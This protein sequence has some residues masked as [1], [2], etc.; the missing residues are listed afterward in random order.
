[1]NRIKW[2]VVIGIASGIALVFVF[3]PPERPRAI[4]KIA[5]RVV[6]RSSIHLPQRRQERLVL[7]SV[8]DSAMATDNDVL[9]AADNYLASQNTRRITEE[10]RAVG[11]VTRSPLGSVVRYDIYQGLLPVVGMRI[12]VHVDHAL[13]VTK[14]DWNYRPIAAVELEEGGPALYDHVKSRLPNGYELRK[15]R[16][17]Y[18]EIIYELFQQGRGEHAVV[19]PVVNEHKIPMSLILRASDGA[20]L[21]AEMP[22]YEQDR[23]RLSRQQAK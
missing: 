20:V 1:M 7:L 22:R 2:L 8:S 9:R 11:R 6:S 17:G 4:R 12:E 10:H 13:K 16:S 14:T 5:P 3:M 23:R 18:S 21:G 15:D 19:V